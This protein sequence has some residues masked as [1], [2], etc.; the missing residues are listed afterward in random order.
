MA[1]YEEPPLFGDQCWICDSEEHH[2]VDC[3]ERGEQ[4]VETIG[5]W[6]Y[7]H[8]LITIVEIRDDFE[9][10][11]QDTYE[12]LTGPKAGDKGSH[13]LPEAWLEREFKSRNESWGKIAGPAE[14]DTSTTQLGM[15][16]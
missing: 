9:T 13:Y 15:D 5:V 10:V 4:H 8:L 6:N 1:D 12:W 7:G 2:D 3:P 14:E 16:F 11:Y